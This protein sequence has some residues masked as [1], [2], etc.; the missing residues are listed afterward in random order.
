M[1][2][3]VYG[4]THELEIVFEHVDGNQWNVVIPRNASGQYYLDLYA[5][6]EAG[7]TTYIAKALFEVDPF[8][9]C[10]KMKILEDENEFVVDESDYEIVCK[11][12]R[13]I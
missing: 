1:V 12:A 9:L 10:Y 11:E 3:K 2:A 8:S 7:N 6:D 5:E 13:C 4:K